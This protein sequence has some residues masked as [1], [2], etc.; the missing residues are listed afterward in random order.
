MADDPQAPDTIIAVCAK[1]NCNYQ[2]KL[3]VQSMQEN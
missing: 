2:N 3:T 1:D